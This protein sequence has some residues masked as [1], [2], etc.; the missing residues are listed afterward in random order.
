MRVIRTSRIPLTPKSVVSVAVVDDVFVD[1]AHHDGVLMIQEHKL[2][3]LP[4][5]RI[6]RLRNGEWND[7]GDLGLVGG[8][9]PFLAQL[10]KTIGTLLDWF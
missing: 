6:F 10:F 8:E 3:M 5:G 9:M 4:S 2:A 7:L 1:G